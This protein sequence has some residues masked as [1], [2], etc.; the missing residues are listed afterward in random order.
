[1]DMGECPPAAGEVAQVTA[2]LAAISGAV[3]AGV[4]PPVLPLP[5]TGSP[6]IRP[7][8]GAAANLQRAL[9]AGSGE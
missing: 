7:A 9:A 4:P 6:G 2:A 1:M 8:A 5:V 3:A